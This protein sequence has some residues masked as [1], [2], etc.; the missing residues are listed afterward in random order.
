[1]STHLVVEGVHG[2][3]ALL[4]G[5]D[6][7]LAGQL[8]GL[9]LDGRGAGS[10]GGGSLRRKKLEALGWGNWLRVLRTE[11]RKGG[12]GESSDSSALNSSETG[13][14]G[15]RT[16]GNIARRERESRRLHRTRGQTTRVLWRHGR[17]IA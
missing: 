15:D 4:Q 5:A 12:D 7:L 9:D 14:K 11:R 8:G 10:T 1:M 16:K 3:L 17:S 2:H 6:Q 13:G